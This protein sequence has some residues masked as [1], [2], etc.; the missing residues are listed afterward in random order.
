MRAADDGILYILVCC[1][2]L[3]QENDS[4]VFGYELRFSS[5]AIIIIIILQLLHLPMPYFQSRRFRSC[6]LSPLTL[7]TVIIF[8]LHR[9]IKCL[10]QIISENKPYNLR[11]C[12]FTLHNTLSLF[13]YF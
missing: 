10:N 8:I 12:T 5:Y 2:L 4:D 3:L 1:H 6:I 11:L 13:F 9:I 7:I